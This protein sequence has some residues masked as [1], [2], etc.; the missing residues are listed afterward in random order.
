MPENI[1]PERPL[2]KKGISDVKK[3][4]GFLIKNKVLIP[5]IWHSTKLRAKQTAELLKDAVEAKTF[6]EKN[7][8][9]P[10]DP[11]DNIYDKIILENDDIL[12]AGHLPFLSKLAS[13]ILGFS[14]TAGVVSFRKGGVVCLEKDEFSKYH[15]LWAI[16]PDLLA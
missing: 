13:K 9:T 11:I 3:V 5:A 14:E 6:K 16:I 7:N 10:N 8:C 15:L 1:D 12:L 4:A 2:T